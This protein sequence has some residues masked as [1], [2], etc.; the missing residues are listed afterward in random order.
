MKSFNVGRRHA[1]R[2]EECI[3]NLVNDVGFWVYVF[4][5]C[6]QATDRECNLYYTPS[7]IFD[8]IS[9]AV[10]LQIKLFYFLQLGKYSFGIYAVL[11]LDEKRKDFPGELSTVGD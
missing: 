9:D 5:L 2:T 1:K 4:S 7:K 6:V 8:N 3:W 11:Y 10:P